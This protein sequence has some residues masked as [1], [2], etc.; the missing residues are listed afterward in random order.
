[1]N[2]KKRSPARYEQISIPDL[3]MLLRQKLNEN[4]VEKYGNRERLKYTK[5]VEQWQKHTKINDS[6]PSEQ[7]LR[8]FYQ[9]KREVF[10]LWV[11]DGL[12]ELLLGYSFEQWCEENPYSSQST[13]NNNF[14]EPRMGVVS[15]QTSN[16]IPN[17]INYVI[18]CQPK[19]LWCFGIHFGISLASNYSDY[20]SILEQGG[21][22]RFLIA[23]PKSNALEVAAEN[24]GIG[25]DKLKT[26]TDGAILSLINLMQAWKKQAKNLNLP[27][28]HNQIK[29]R[30]TY[31]LFFM[32]AYIINPDSIDANSIFIP[33][34]NNLRSTNETPMFIAKN[35]KDGLSQ[36]YIQG[37]KK[38]WESPK[39]IS[40]QMFLKET[41]SKRFTKDYPEI[42]EDYPDEL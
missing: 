5:L 26:E 24:F 39:T 41:G 12:C 35:I 28:Y 32:R 30:L 7:T 9:L 34:M 22:I 25:K 27:E 17:I 14:Y 37:V 6:P 16:R 13:N 38:E 20:L 11:I 8:D 21:V 2:K 40:L 18:S 19:E 15:V 3:Q 33:Y 42:L 23:H 31:S 36:K 4:Y 10:S 1:M 29:A